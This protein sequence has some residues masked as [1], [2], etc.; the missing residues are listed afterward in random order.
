MSRLALVLSL[1]LLAALPAAADAAKVRK[2]P[3]GKAFYTAPAKLHQGHP[4][5]R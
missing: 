4:Q 5:S 2:G 3:A 1:L